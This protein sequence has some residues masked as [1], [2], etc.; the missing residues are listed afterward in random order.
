M[1]FLFQGEICFWEAPLFQ[2]FNVEIFTKVRTKVEIH[3]G[4]SGERVEIDPCQQA[5]TARFWQKQKAVSYDLD[6][7]VSC[8]VVERAGGR[9]AAVGGRQM[10]RKGGFF[11]IARLYGTYVLLS[12]TGYL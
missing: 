11:Y 9:G 3:L 6:Q 8:E 10:F 2:S 1:F 12:D 4:I 5:S 7:V